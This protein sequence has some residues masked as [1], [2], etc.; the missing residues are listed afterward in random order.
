MFP[1]PCIPK[2]IRNPYSD[3]LTKLTNYWPMSEATG[4]QRSDRKGVSHLTDVSSNVLQID[5]KIGKCADFIGISDQYLST[6]GSPFDMSD[7]WEIFGWINPHDTLPGQNYSP[8]SKDD[9][10]GYRTMHINLNPAGPNIRVTTFAE[11]N[12]ER[13]DLYSVTPTP[14]G[15]NFFCAWYYSPTKTVYIQSNNGAISSHQRSAGVGVG[16][17]TIFVGRVLNY[18]ANASIG[19]IGAVMGNILTDSDR[20]LLWNNGYGIALETF[21]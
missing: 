6:P 2:S 5:G 12:T 13:Y 14:I 15:W 8:F 4:S 9:G 1:I 10:V 18:H 16:N 19:P 17:S 21:L 3:I 20:S 11:D 7:S